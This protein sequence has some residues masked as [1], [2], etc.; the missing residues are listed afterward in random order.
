M[1][2]NATLKAQ[3]AEFQKKLEAQPS[4]LEEKIRFYQEKQENIRKLSVLDGFVESLVEVG[5]EVQDE[6]ENDEF[7]TERFA[8]RISKKSNSYR[9]DFDDIVKIKNPVLVA[10]ML[11]YIMERINTKRDLLKSAING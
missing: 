11:G 4:S 1:K 6:S 8:V 7:S 10:E 3:L 5:K 9:E 2:E